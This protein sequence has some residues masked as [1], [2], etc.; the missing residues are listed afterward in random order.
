MST[1]KVYVEGADDEQAQLMVTCME[2]WAM[3]DPAT[4]RRVFDDCLQESA[5][6]PLDG[7]EERPHDQVQDALQ[8]ATRT[9]GPRRAYRKGERSFEVLAELH[10]DQLARNLG[11]F[12][13]LVDTL[14]R[15]LEQA[16]YR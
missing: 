11:Y 13:R 9:C 1:V 4:L 8:H 12:A 14:D 5:L 16:E 6:L 7:L 15:H 3:A 2:T 10:P